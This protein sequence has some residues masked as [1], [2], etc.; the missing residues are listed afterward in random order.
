MAGVN[1]KLGVEYSQFRTGMKDA[2]AQ[3]QTLN[4]KL[5]TNESQL[6]L[7]GDQEIYLKNKVDLLN[8]QIA[9]Q[10]TVVG[11][12]L[13]ALKA[14]ANSGVST[15]SAQYQKMEQNVY[16]AT[17]KLNKMQIELQETETGA[18]KAGNEAA[19]MNTQLGKIGQDVSFKNVTDGLNSIIGKLESGAR[20]A[21]NFGKKI[22]NS[23]K[24]SADW[25]DE[26][27]TLS[28]TSGIDITTLQQM[29]KV[30][31]IVET[32]V[33]AIVNAKKRMQ[34]AATTEGGVKSIEEVL[35]I[36]LNGQ[37]AEDLF[38]EIGD[39]LV[40]MEES[41]DK[42]SAA[43]T[44]FGRSWSE[45]VPLFNLGREAYEEMLSEQSTLTEE[46]VKKL[47]EADDAM[48]T[49]EQQIQDMKN[50][51][52]ADNADTVI[53]LLEWVVENKEAVVTALGAIAAGFA[54][55]KIATFAT[56]LAKVIKGFSQLGLLGGG[57]TGTTTG[58]AAQAGSAA[59]AAGASATGGGWLTG[60]M[61]NMV[62][63]MGT[64][65]VLGEESRI[66]NTLNEAMAGLSLEEQKAKA[67]EQ[68][69]GI[70]QA[71]FNEWESGS[72]GTS[73]GASFDTQTKY[74]DVV[75][76]EI[77]HKDRRGIKTFEGGAYESVDRMTEVASEMNEATNNQTDATNDM[78]AAATALQSLPG[79]IQAA[80]ISGMSSVTITI[81]ASG[82]DAM[83][84]RIAS[85][86]TDNIVNLVK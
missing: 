39:A 79:L 26:L 62:S 48:V 11:N 75:S 72:K 1:V 73:G 14:L 69:F 3:V 28:Q 78:T 31:D 43:Q 67:F 35:G 70:T 49:I 6:K 56:E 23:V 64:S 74:V 24:D 25:A 50:A 86:I 59:P 15:A 58:A 38:W 27:L 83:T 19:E 7:T 63:G 82:V 66:R 55:M 60:L 45:L 32:D 71:E 41:F 65:F 51:F 80:V 4:E 76:D 8:Q 33:D 17:D 54:A 21:I 2:Q 81:D 77:I 52:W 20:S 29:E 84:P 9:A 42:E 36:S 47:G 12:A 16:K 44:V 37:S 10:R 13:E 68:T 18:D 30:A 61:N 85:G 57:Q 46:Q 22:Y 34:K 5:K 53:S 40:N